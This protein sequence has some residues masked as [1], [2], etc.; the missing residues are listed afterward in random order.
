M[1]QV[2]DQRRASVSAYLVLAGPFLAIGVLFL[3]A[4][5]KKS[6]ESN[7]LE[8]SWV[9]LA[10][11][12]AWIV[13]LSGF[14]VTMSEESLSYRNGF[15]QNRDLPWTSISDIETCFVT[16]PFL[17]RSIQVPR[18][19]VITSEADREDILINPKPFPRTLKREI[20]ARLKKQSQE[21]D[22]TKKSPIK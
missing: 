14:R 6:G 22:M 12:L 17:P 15:F 2:F 3:V 19:R 10:I 18:F 21:L 16:W 13:W 4:A 7:V 9:C 1:N 8:G 11:A 20:L 5:L